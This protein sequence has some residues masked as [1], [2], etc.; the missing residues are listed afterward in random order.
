MLPVSLQLHE[1]HFLRQAVRRV[2]F[3]RIAVPEILFT[4]RHRCKF[5]VGADGARANKL[6]N[7]GN[8]R[9]LDNVQPHRGVFIEEAPGI[10]AVGADAAYDC[11]QMNEDIRARILV[12]PQ[13]F[14]LFAQV[15]LAAPRNRDFPAAR[16]TQLLNN[17]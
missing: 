14:R 9:R 7:S 4:K 10:G 6:F 11:R 13:S 17:E 16:R 8:A 15:V 1:Q 3:F 12:E 5:G 2:G